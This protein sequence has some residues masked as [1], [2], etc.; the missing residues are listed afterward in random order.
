VY[1]LQESSLLLNALFFSPI[2]ETSLYS[3]C[4][5]APRRERNLRNK[6]TRT[7]Q[8]TNKSF[9]FNHPCCTEV[10]LPHFAAEPRLRA[11]WSFSKNSLGTISAQTPRPAR[12]RA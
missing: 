8:E 6:R 7:A 12:I 3:V 2:R 5:Q 9:G 1:P 11:V 4:T 10:T